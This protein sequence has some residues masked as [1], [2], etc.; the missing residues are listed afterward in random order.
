MRALQSILE[1]YS[2]RNSALL[3]YLKDGKFDPY[4]AWWAV[5]EWVERNDLL[6]AMSRFAGEPIN[7]AEDLQDHEPELFYQ[8]DE[9]EQNA[10]AE[11]CV[12]YIMRHDPANAPTTAH[13]S[14]NRNQLIPRV[15]WLVHF[16]DE[17][18]NIARTGFTH[19][20]DEMDRLGL[21][22]YFT[23]DA[24]KRGGYN[25]AF[26]ATS[27]HAQNAAWNNKYGLNAVLFQNSG[28]HC[29]HYG[30]EEDQV[31]FWGADVNPKRMIYLDRPEGVW[32]VRNVK[33]G[34][35]LFTA[36]RYL[37]VVEWVIKNEAQYR[38]SLYGG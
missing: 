31:I 15:T 18:E 2:E 28:V 9:I 17:A 13:V 33:T 22:T 32:Q 25:F 35:T 30:D 21:T 8:L 3:G 38:R 36:D 19:G 34:N 16:S 6:G 5:C 23:H 20:M 26:E 11:W 29:T 4:S 1:N 27:R 37:K 10:C 7:S 12:D 24:K 14:L